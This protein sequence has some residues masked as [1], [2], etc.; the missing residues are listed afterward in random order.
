MSIINQRS[1]HV[2]GVP[3]CTNHLLLKS[4]GL[5]MK[6]PPIKPWKLGPCTLTFHLEWGPRKRFYAWTETPKGSGWNLWF[7][8]YITKIDELVNGVIMAYINQQTYLGAPSCTNHPILGYLILIHAIWV[9]L[10]LLPSPTRRRFVGRWCGT[11]YVGMQIH[12]IDPK[13]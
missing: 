5:L 8:V 2:W 6:S 1:H 9:V 12:M 7:M 11:F 4:Q 3:P 10:P 13:S